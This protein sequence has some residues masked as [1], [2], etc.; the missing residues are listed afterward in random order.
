MAV[1]V[2]DDPASMRLGRE[3][4]RK[5]VGREFHERMAEASMRLGRERPRKDGVDVLRFG[6]GDASMRLGRERPRKVGANF[7]LGNGP[8]KLQ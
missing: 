7:N 3:R 2:G 4:P 5:G 8:D 1:G 6:Q